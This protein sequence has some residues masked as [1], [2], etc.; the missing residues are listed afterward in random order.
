MNRH[1]QNESPPAR[2][3]SYTTA[4]VSSGRV[5]R[6]ERHVER[7]RRDAARLGLP[8]PDRL[9][10]ETLLLETAREAFGRGDGIVR[11]EWS[12][13]GSSPESGTVPRP[14]FRTETRP[15]G[16][17]P[18]R[19]R[20]VTSKAVHPGPGERR[21]TKFVGVEA[22]DLARAEVRERSVDE[23][24]LFDPDGFLVEGSRTNILLVDAAGR[25]STPDPELGAVEG[26]GLSL[27]REDHPELR[28]VRVTYD[29]V[30]S[31]R[32]LLAVNCVRG[33]VPITELD[34]API[35]KGE[36]GPWAGRLRPIFFREPPRRR[37]ENPTSRKEK[38]DDDGGRSESG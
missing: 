13:T 33:I 21:N 6:V 28:F 31:A 26:I 11:I 34:G 9:A 7:L 18:D 30:R 12:R 4:R 15:I 22:W 16:K 37:P 24:L 38:R 20:A 27:V 17:E 1:D 8:L 2:F 5:E 23:V 3:G 35:S 19:W 10:T 36:P 32:E 14:G 29:C 25:L